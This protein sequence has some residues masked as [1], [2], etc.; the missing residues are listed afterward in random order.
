MK[1]ILADRPDYRIT[2]HQAGPVPAERLVI[3]FG[4]QPSG[5]RDDGFGTD[6]CL[7]QGWDTIYVAQRHGTQYQGLSLA[8][9]ADAVAPLCAGR[10]VVTYGPSLGGY[11]ALYYGGIIDARIIAAAPML[12]AWRP[13]G[14]KAYLD[15]TVTHHDLPGGP[16]ATRAPVV[17]LDP[18]LKNDSRV[19]AEMVR[20]AYPGVRVVEV[21]HAGHAVL[22]PLQRARI[23]GPLI[24]TLIERDEIIAFT[25]PGPGTAIY[26]GQRGHELLQQDRRAAIEQLRISL[27]IEPN[28]RFFGIMVN[29]LIRSGQTAAAQAELD[30]A[31]ALNDT[32]LTLTPR[33]TQDAVAA[34]L[35]LHPPQALAA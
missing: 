27:E 4:G 1:T 10:D 25:P 21:P 34:G 14:H 11:A 17:I 16:L 33:L 3:T 19:L 28:K 35:R 8:A 29:A 15:L 26:H 2:L 12:P 18:F 5:I 7:R 13:L 24:T 6:F 23:L 9:F 32:R 22:I 31:A 30:R 20:P